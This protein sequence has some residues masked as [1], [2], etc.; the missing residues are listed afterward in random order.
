MS[1]DD[2]TE[3][4]GGFGSWERVGPDPPCAG[5]L[6]V[7]IRPT[8]GKE[9]GSCGPGGSEGGSGERRLNQMSPAP[10]QHMSS[11]VWSAG[12]L[13]YKNNSRHNLVWI[14]RACMSR[15]FES[16]FARQDKRP[17]SHQTLGKWIP[18]FV[19]L[20]ASLSSRCDGQA[21]A[22]CDLRLPPSGPPFPPLLA[23]LVDASARN[24][25]G[26]EQLRAKV[27]ARVRR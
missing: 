1:E 6:S 15:C 20:A 18:H 26:R 13:R 5:K 21:R 9:R 2:K 25:A 12:G 19:F 7:P 27:R 10:E 8:Q 4:V 16:E 14:V 17:F 22:R 23:S 3:A 24:D 11:L